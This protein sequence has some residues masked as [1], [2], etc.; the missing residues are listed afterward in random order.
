MAERDL[1]PD[2]DR[3]LAVGDV[4]LGGLDDGGV[5]GDPER[6]SRQGGRLVLDPVTLFHRHVG[7]P[8][9]QQRAEPDQALQGDRVAADVRED[10]RATARRPADHSETLERLEGGADGR[11]A[12]V[13]DRRRT[14]SG[15]S[16]RLGNRPSKT[17]SSSAS[18]VCSVSVPCPIG[19]SWVEFSTVTVASLLHVSYRLQVPC[20][21]RPARQGSSS[22]RRS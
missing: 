11:A 19:S 4:E 22:R 14:G 15:G 1:V 9:T 8:L 20:G 10:D 3:R 21:D 13:E 18:V 6:F 2:V 17:A 16:L 7:I 5:V 12:D